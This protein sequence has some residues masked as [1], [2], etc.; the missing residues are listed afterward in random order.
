M[1][2][3]RRANAEASRAGPTGVRP[4]TV[5]RFRQSSRERLVDELAAGVRDRRVLAAI[6]AVPRDVFVPED[7]R[8]HAWANT[9]LPIGEGQTISQPYVV[10]RMCEML[11]LTGDETVLDVGTGSGYHAAV[12]A[13]LAARVISIERI[14]ALSEQARVALAAAGVENVE[15]VTGDGTLGHPP[16]APYDA[17]NVAAAA[18][19]VPPALAEQLADGGRMVIPSNGGAQRLLLVRRHGEELEL[20]P[21]D[22]VRFVPLVDAS[23]VDRGADG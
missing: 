20:V 15:L 11:E 8:H 14:E 4:R 16:A 6:A 3:Q 18:G 9:S 10:A 21:H 23:R 7:L 19:G 17:I 13:R 2:R 12:L 5:P 22:P 1:H